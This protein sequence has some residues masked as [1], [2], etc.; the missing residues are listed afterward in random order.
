MAG[1]ASDA[2]AFTATNRAV[3]WKLPGLP[4]G[5]TKAVAVKL[6]AASAG[7]VVFRTVAVAAPDASVTPAGVGTKP[8]GRALEAKSETAIKAEGVAAVRF[9]VKGLENPV[10]VGKDAVYEIRITNQGTGACSNVQVMAAMAENTTF[11]GSNGPTTV[12][13]QGQ[14]LVFDPIA[15]LPVKGEMVYTVR[16]RGN[17]PGDQRFR[18]QLT[19]DQVRT[20]VVKEESTSF[21]KQ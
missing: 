3:S 2:G 19:C 17:A 16:V 1:K 8:A 20:P 9:D 13:A 14:T 6:R 12:K 18:V 11:S 4:A 10:E 21:Y 15:T 5:G 7:D